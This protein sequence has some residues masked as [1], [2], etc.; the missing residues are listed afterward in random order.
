MKC[1]FGVHAH[2]KDATYAVSAKTMLKSAYACT[3]HLHWAVNF[4]AGT[5]A[6]IAVPVE[7]KRIFG[8]R[9]RGQKDAISRSIGAV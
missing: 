3:Q 6:N 1:E 7:V 5:T 9:D 8:G 4:L 2:Q